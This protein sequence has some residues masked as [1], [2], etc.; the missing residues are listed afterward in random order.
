MF[1]QR[2]RNGWTPRAVQPR[3]RLAR[4][5]VE[6]IMPHY[7]SRYTLKNLVT[8]MTHQL[9]ALQKCVPVKHNRNI[10]CVVGNLLFLLTWSMPFPAQKPSKDNAILKCG[11]WKK[12]NK[13]RLSWTW[14]TSFDWILKSDW[15]FASRKRWFHENSQPLNLAKIRFVSSFQALMSGVMWFSFSVSLNF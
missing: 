14:K 11:N 3:A 2:V 9:I 4:A 7:V 10:N 5:V 13:N 1:S 6:W 15:T 8:I 12:V